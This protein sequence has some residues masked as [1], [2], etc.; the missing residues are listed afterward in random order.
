MIIGRQWTSILI[1]QKL[2]L[3]IEALLERK[4]KLLEQIGFSHLNNNIKN[5]GELFYPVGRLFIRSNEEEFSQNNAKRIQEHELDHSQLKINKEKLLLKLSDSINDLNDMMESDPHYCLK[6]ALARKMNLESRF[7]LDETHRGRWLV[8]NTPTAAQLQSGPTCGL[9]ALVTVARARGLELR[10]D[11]VLDTGRRLGLTSRGEM[12]SADWMA[13]LAREVMPEARVRLEAA[14]MLEDTPGLLRL[15]LGAGLV[16]VPYDCAANSAVCLAGGEKA[17]WAV[18]TGLVVEA[19]PGSPQTGAS[20][21][22]LSSH[23]LVTRA[24]LEEEETLAHL[25]TV[26]RDRVK[27]VVR[28]SK[29][30]ELEIYNRLKTKFCATSYDIF[31][32]LNYWRAV[33]S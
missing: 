13:S 19:G 17:H 9:V 2:L 30:L 3:E 15:L 32:E 27:L 16:L 21:G 6:R 11:Q 29:T 10:V 1:L 5:A 31:L 8:H 20:L 18:V 28:Q 22:G 14:S 33:L 24:M 25:A 7:G 4:E 12:F 23:H 26:N